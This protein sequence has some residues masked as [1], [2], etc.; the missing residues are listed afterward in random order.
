GDGPG[1]VNVSGTELT[2]G[3]VRPETYVPHWD[4]PQ[5]PELQQAGAFPFGPTPPHIKGRRPDPPKGCYCRRAGA[6]HLHR[7]VR[8][9]VQSAKFGTGQWVDGGIPFFSRWSAGTTIGRTPKV[10]YGGIV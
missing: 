9:V 8:A 5:G 2:D 3:W 6:C 10:E 1:L 7:R 4:P